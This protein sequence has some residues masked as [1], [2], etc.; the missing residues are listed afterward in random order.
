MRP[1]NNMP[2]ATT[3]NY[4]KLTD[5]LWWQYIYFNIFFL[6][7]SIKAAKALLDTKEK[8]VQFA[9]MLV[10]FRMCQLR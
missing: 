5:S 9:S 7:L 3:Q 1:F 2:R 4:T 10:Y 6:N 8:Q